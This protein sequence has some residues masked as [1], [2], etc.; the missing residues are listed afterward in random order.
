MWGV[1]SDSPSLESLGGSSLLHA[2]LTQTA[3]SAFFF[4]MLPCLLQE[5]SEAIAEFL[6]D[7]TAGKALP[8]FV[9]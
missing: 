9:R 8:L 6:F 4:L 5:C 7:G 2:G 1:S 3:L